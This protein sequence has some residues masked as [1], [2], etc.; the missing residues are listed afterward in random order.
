MAENLLL[1]SLRSELRRPL[2]DQLTLVSLEKGQS[3]ANVEGPVRHVYFPTT[4]LVSIFGLTA[5]GGMVELGAIARDG[6]IGATDIL[7]VASM[8]HRAIVCLPGAALC[9]ERQTLRA[10]M[11]RDEVLR[12]I[13]HGHTSR[14]VA[15]LAQA[16]I[17]H[18]FHSVLQRLCRWLL[19]AADRTEMLVFE[20]TH[21]RLAHVLGVARPVLSRAALELHDAAAI[22]SRRGRVA[23][24]NRPVLEQLTCECYGLLRR[25]TPNEIG[26]QVEAARARASADSHHW[27]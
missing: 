16:V 4:G 7:A 26:P 3:L 10:S 22:H 21:E 18:R 12:K 1:A 27:S 2:F 23:L 5:D 15:E 11:E 24:L 17:C 19:T 13:L 9:L 8:P 20:V 14:W 6:C 25:G